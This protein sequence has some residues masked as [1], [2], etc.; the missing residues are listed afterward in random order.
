M[1]VREIEK[2][3]VAVK[4][5]SFRYKSRILNTYR[6]KSYGRKNLQQQG[7]FGGDSQH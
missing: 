6:K 4:F 3:T 2:K 5:L 7:F 1:I